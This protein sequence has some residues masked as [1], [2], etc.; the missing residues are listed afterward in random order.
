MKPIF[1]GRLLGLG[2]KIGKFRA[3]HFC[4][5]LSISDLDG[6]TCVTVYQYFKINQLPNKFVAVN[7]ADCMKKCM[8]DLRCRRVYYHNKKCN[9]Y[10]NFAAAY[11][12]SF[13]RVYVLEQ[14][15]RQI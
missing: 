4:M 10:Y 14:C 7:E 8:N 11:P 3:L 1:L 13:G 2:K 9:I 12:E 5:S 15:A 6:L